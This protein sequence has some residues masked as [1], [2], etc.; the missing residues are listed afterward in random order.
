[1][2]WGGGTV[3]AARRAGRYGLGMLG[4]ANAPGM[5]QA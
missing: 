5:Q 4:N 3:A 1:M 2:L